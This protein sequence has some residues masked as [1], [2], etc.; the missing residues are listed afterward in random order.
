MY[1]PTLLVFSLLLS[2]SIYLVGMGEK[3]P[4]RRYTPPS[5]LG[6]PK[7]QQ[8]KPLAE[9]AAMKKT[10]QDIA[11][12]ITQLHEGKALPECML[13]GMS[14]KAKICGLQKEL[15]AALAAQKKFEKK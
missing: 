11:G 13:E 7:P 12:V 6:G 8:P 9:S 10:K 5:V 4:L 1:K 14:R 15:E 3:N 2:S